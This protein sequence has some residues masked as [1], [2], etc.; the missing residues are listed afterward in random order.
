MLIAHVEQQGVWTIDGG[1]ARLAAAMAGLG[2]QTG[3]GDPPRRDGG[4]RLSVRNRR[5][6]GCHAGERRADRSRC[7]HLRRRLSPRYRRACSGRRSAAR[8]RGE[9]RQPVAVGG[10]LGAFGDRGS[11]FPLVRHNVFFS[12][13][14]AAEFDAIFGRGT[15]PAEP[16]VYVCAQDRRDGEPAI[17]RNAGTIAGP[18]Q[19]AGQRRSPRTTPRRRSSDARQRPSG[20]L[21]RCG[22]TLE[23]PARRRRW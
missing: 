8:C 17:G 20:V 22:L 11:G 19:R 21:A 9:A 2:H 7:G 5:A 10:D 6:A 13:D 4:R 3:R 15:M 14:Y 1:M 12:R 18:D 16:T 23:L